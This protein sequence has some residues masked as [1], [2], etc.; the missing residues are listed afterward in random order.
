MICKTVKPKSG[1]PHS[2]DSGLATKI[3]FPLLSKENIL[4]MI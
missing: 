2:R 1:N 3:Y 4:D